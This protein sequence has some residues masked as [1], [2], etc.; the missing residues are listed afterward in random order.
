LFQV[1]GGDGDVARRP[2]AG[3]CVRDVEGLLA[4]NAAALGR[5]VM[6]R[7]VSRLSMDDLCKPADELL[8]LE[9]LKLF[10]GSKEPRCVEERLLE[11]II[12]IDPPAE[13]RAELEARK[14]PGSLAIL[15]AER[16]E[17]LSCGTHRIR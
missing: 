11:E 10:F 14:A 17:A 12:A 16:L 8:S 2:A 7:E 3:S 1:F 4:A 9:R 15:L 5:Q 13:S 6:A